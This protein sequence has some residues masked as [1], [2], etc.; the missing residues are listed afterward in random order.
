LVGY[1]MAYGLLSQVSGANPDVVRSGG[2]CTPNGGCESINTGEPA[3]W[4]LQTM[5]LVGVL[6]L[7]AAAV[8]NVLLLRML[9]ARRRN[10]SK[11]PANPR[12]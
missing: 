3:D 11:S 2:R 8:L 1:Y 7:A 5:D 9:T 4:F 12:P 10:R 6:A